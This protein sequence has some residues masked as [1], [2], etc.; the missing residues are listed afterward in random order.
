MH[1]HFKVSHLRK[2]VPDRMIRLLRLAILV[3]CLTAGAFLGARAQELPAVAE[4]IYQGPQNADRISLV[5]NVDWGEE[6][7]QPMLDICE[8]KHVRLTFF[9]TGRWAKNHHELV[10][11]I[12]EGGHEIGNHGY[13]HP[14]PNSL[15]VPNNMRDIQRAEEVLESI[16]GKKPRLF[17]PP[18]GERG[19][20]VLEAA[21]S[22][23][24]AT[25]LWSIDTVDWDCQDAAVIHRRAVTKAEPGSIVLMHPTR[26]TLAALPGILDELK[27]KG[28]EI[29]IVSRLIETAPAP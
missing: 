18:Y 14:H 27:S 25:V 10:R 29:V 4:P 8:A 1:I 28:F 5:V 7:L 13:A 26:A 6:Y 3:G 9:I 22:L 23:G 12:A 24:Y 16:T 19:P 15:N 20:A 21:D 17:A 2:S 11:A